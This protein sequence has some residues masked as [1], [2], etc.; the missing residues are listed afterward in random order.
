MR[1]ALGRALLS[2][3]ALIR[4][5]SALPSSFLRWSS[6][7][8][9]GPQD[10]AIQPPVFV[11]SFPKSGTHLLVQ[12]AAGLPGRKNYGTFLASMTSSFWFRERTVVDTCRCIQRFAPG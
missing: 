9:A 1:A 7:R 4:K 6:A 8:K 12:L 2:K 5:A 3:Y 10:F 11:N